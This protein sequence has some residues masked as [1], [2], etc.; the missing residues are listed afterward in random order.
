MLEMGLLQDSLIQYKEK[1]KWETYI[2]ENK[3]LL[4][5]IK[6]GAKCGKT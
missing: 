6:M 1:D 4:Q 2:E 5:H 3:D